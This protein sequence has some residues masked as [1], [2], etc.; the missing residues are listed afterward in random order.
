MF[1]SNNTEMDLLS[2]PV[3]NNYNEVRG[4]NLSTNRSVSRNLLMSSTMSS[5]VYHKRMVNNGMDVNE[6]LVES[7]PALSYE[8][9][10]E[11]AIHISKAVEQQGNMRPKGKNLE[12]PNSNLKCIPNVEQCNFPA[13]GTVSQTEDDNVINIQLSYDPQAPTEPDLWNSNF[14]PISLYSSIKHITSDAKNIR[15]SLN[16]IARYI[17]NKKVNPSKTNDLEDFNSIGNSI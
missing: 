13:R 11:K 10:Q 2:G 9:E 5:V 4:K 17:S 16:F 1:P 6:R 15:D 7:T 12:I 14:Y 3:P 8:I